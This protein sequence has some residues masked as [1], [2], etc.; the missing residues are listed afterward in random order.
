MSRT[1]T[2]VN[3]EVKLPASAKKGWK[4]VPAFQ[5]FREKDGTVSLFAVD[6]GL[7]SAFER[8][9]QSL[10]QAGANGFA[11]VIIDDVPVQVVFEAKTFRMRHGKLQ[12]V[13]EIPERL[14]I[15]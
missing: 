4:S 14:Y 10:A 3:F 9:C 5:Y 8:G 2:V 7:N 12:F 11:N 15:D 1:I 13:S 6:G